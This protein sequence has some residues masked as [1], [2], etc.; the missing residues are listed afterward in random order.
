[1]GKKA[2]RPKVYENQQGKRG[3]PTLAVRLPPEVHRHIT[4]QPEGPRGY[5]VRLV[6]EDMD[7]TAA[8]EPAKESTDPNDVPGQL[9]LPETGQQ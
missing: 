4:E 6:T 9:L 2:G 3:A 7:K 1:M 5:I 8:T